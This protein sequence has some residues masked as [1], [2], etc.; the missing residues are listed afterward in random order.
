[1]FYLGCGGAGGGLLE[2][3]QVSRKKPWMCQQ[4]ADSGWSKEEAECAGAPS[5][6]VATRV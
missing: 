5:T 2:V 4:L 1:M 3:Q 6:V